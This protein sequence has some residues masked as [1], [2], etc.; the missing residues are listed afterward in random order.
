MWVVGDRS[1]EMVSQLWDRLPFTAEQRLKA[2]FHTNLWAAYDEP[3]LEI[4]HVTREGQINHVERLNCT[5]K[6]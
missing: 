5:L 3:L 2:T 1:Q 4:R 6:W